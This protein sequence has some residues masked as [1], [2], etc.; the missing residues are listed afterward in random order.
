MVKST[1]NALS[2]SVQVRSWTWCDKIKV[3]TGLNIFLD[4]IEKKSSPTV[5]TT[6]VEHLRLFFIKEF[7]NTTF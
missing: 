1:T 4:T 3:L 7:T 5:T 6:A 2:C